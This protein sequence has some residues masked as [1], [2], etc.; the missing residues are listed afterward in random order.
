MT[1][2]II[3]TAVPAA[4][5]SKLQRRCSCALPCIMK[6]P[7]QEERKFRINLPYC[8]HIYLPWHLHE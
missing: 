7:F 6:I 8:S 3:A 4:L 1:G 5:P 2:I